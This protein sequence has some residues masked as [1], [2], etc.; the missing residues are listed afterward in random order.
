[1]RSPHNITSSLRALAC[2]LAAAAAL[3]QACGPAAAPPSSVDGSLLQ[4]RQERDQAFKSSGQSPL[5]EKDRELFRGLDYFPVN[6]ALRFH[7]NF[8]RYPVPERIRLATNTG[9]IRDGLRYGYFEFTTE[10]QVCRLQAYRMDDGDNSGQPVL[11][12]PFRDKTSGKE[13]YAAGR[14]IDLPENT[15]GIYDLDFNRAY[16]PFCAYSDHYSCPIPPDENRLRVPIRAGEKS[17]KHATPH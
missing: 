9:E 1:M 17:Y 4:A 13:T 14:Y 2:C 6:P 12:I 16:N 8:N 15:S 7:L 10:G 11:F 5:P 3:F